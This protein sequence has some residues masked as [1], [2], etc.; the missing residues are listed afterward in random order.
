MYGFDTV[1]LSDV[2]NEI[3]KPDEGRINILTGVFKRRDQPVKINVEVD[4][5]PVA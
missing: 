1:S 2:E 3:R 4:S 5:L